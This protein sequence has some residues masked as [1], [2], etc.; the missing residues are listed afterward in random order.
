MVHMV[1]F[2]N[3]ILSILQP[4]SRKSRPPANPIPEAHKSN[5]LD[6]VFL[7]TCRLEPLS[8][9]REPP[10]PKN[11]N[12]PTQN[13]SPKINPS[14][15]RNKEDKPSVKLVNE[16]RAKLFLFFI[17]RTSKQLFYNFSEIMRSIC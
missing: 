9:L 14:H 1:G 10:Q 2:A 11:P 8:P 6:Q 7:H 16:E 5:I 3:N 13:P 15:K 17:K 4:S 12:P